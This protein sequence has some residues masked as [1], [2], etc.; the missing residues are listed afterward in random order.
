MLETDYLIVGAGAT[1]MA[2]AEIILSESDASMIIADRYH[3]PGV[4]WNLAYPFVKPHQPARTGATQT[5]QKFY[6]EMKP[7]FSGNI[8]TP[9]TV[10]GA[11]LVF[12]SAFIAHVEVAYQEERLKNELCQV[13]PLPDRDTD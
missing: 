7:V 8:I 10:R 12:S 3:K 11:Q 9:Q 6:S 5:D 2:F 1:G 13:V 4:H